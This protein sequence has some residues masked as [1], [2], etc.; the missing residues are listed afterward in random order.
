MP[1][2]DAA[3]R[4]AMA[5]AMLVP[6]GKAIFRPTFSVLLCSNLL[7]GDAAVV[8]VAVTSELPADAPHHYQTRCLVRSSLLALSIECTERS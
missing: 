6:A 1:F 5:C 3:S 7:D 2:P 8:E 4:L